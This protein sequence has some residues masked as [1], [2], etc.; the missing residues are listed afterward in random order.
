MDFVWGSY[1]GTDTLSLVQFSKVPKSAKGAPF[2]SSNRSFT[3]LHLQLHALSLVG[4]DKFVTY[5]LNSYH[6]SSDA[7][8][9]D[10]LE[11]AVPVH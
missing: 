8:K 5:L 2:S 11:L 7:L 4:N 3:L 6:I 1:K 10:L 9:P